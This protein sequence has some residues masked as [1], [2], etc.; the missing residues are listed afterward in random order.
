[1]LTD[2]DNIKDVI[3]FP[4]TQTAQD[5]M[6]QTPATVTQEQLNILSLYVLW[7]EIKLIKNFIYPSP[8][9]VNPWHD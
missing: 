2:T 1:L 5:L 4:K 3:A 9:F 7:G 8:Y 6:L